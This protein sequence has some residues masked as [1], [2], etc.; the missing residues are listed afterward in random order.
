MKRTRW[1]QRRT[2]KNTGFQET[3]GRTAFVR[4]PRNHR[5]LSNSMERQRK[6]NLSGFNRLR[7]SFLPS[8]ILIHLHL[9]LILFYRPFLFSYSLF[10]LHL[11]LSYSQWQC[12]ASL[13]KSTKVWRICNHRRPR[14]Y[15]Q[16]ALTASWQN[17]QHH[18]RDQPGGFVAL[19]IV[20]VQRGK[21]VWNYIFKKKSL[22]FFGGLN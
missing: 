21:V 9:S 3:R 19:C 12:G 5:H 18:P 7:L 6:V 8:L 17:H 20:Q 11:S 4:K 22:N 10:S 14:P 13:H 15:N 1:R 16:A 2:I